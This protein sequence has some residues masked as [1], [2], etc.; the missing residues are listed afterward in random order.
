MIVE[1][2]LKN[3]R[4]PKDSAVEVLNKLDTDKDGYISLGEIVAKLKELA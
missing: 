4:I 1:W 3:V 2:L